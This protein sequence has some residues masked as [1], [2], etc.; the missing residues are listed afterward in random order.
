M[1][2]GCA[3]Q[4]GNIGVK[5]YSTAWITCIQTSNLSADVHTYAYILQLS[6]SRGQTAL[7]TWDMTWFTNT[8]LNA[9][10]RAE[11]QRRYGLNGWEFEVATP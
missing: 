6:P 7:R 3:A 5:G 2:L 10:I 11:L 9:A 8:L 4:L 1:A